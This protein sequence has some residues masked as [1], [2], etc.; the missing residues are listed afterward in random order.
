MMAM[1]MGKHVYCE[2]PLTYDI[3]EARTLTEAA[4]KYKIMTQMGNQARRARNHAAGRVRPQRH[5]RRDQG[6]H[7]Y[8]DRPIWPQGLSGRPRARRA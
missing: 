1:R 6:S 7:V 4:R 2:K 3:Y 8:T 5:R